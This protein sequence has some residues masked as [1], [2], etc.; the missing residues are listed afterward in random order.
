MTLVNRKQE[1]VRSISNLN[2]A[3]SEEVLNFIKGLLHTQHKD[4]YQQHLKSKAIQEIGQALK[5]T[6]PIF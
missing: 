3:Q 1:I 4:L 5:Q 6:Q 2:A